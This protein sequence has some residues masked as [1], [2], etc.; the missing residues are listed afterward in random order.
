M[1]I[2]AGYDIHQLFSGV[3][4]EG[5]ETRKGLWIM[6]M[7]EDLRLCFLRPVTDR[8]SGRLVDHV[9]KISEALHDDVQ[10]VAYF[11][12]ASATATVQP[13]EG[14]LSE[15]G[16]DLMACPQLE[17]YEL[18]GHVIYDPEGYISSIPLYSFQD[19]LGY[20]HLPRALAV[21]GPHDFVWA[22]TCLACTQYRRRTVELRRRHADRNPSERGR[23]L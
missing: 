9:E 11:A 21:E 8:M 4:R 1:I 23:Q 6:A 5:T 10:E 7:D 17:D 13:E 2:E 14:R 22:C 3:F 15:I 19:Y 12:L 20:G 18:L 16:R